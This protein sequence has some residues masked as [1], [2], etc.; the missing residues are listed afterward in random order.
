MTLTLEGCETCY[1]CGC[2]TM[3]KW[4]SLLEMARACQNPKCGAIEEREKA[5]TTRV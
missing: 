5:G 1:K 3:P 2:I 4:R